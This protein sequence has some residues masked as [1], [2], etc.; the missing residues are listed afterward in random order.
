MSSGTLGRPS[1]NRSPCQSGVYLITSSLVK[2]PSCA[3]RQGVNASKAAAPRT[4]AIILCMLF[5]LIDDV[6]EQLF[7]RFEPRCTGNL[8]LFCHFL[9][10]LH[11]QAGPIRRS[12]VTIHDDFAFL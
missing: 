6:A 3:V 4:P 8:R 12:H 5:P 11:T 2:N 7:F 10:H 1:A 9:V